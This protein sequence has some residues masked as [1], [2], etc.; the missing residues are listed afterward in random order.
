M[1]PY[2]PEM[3]KIVILLASIAVLV[4]GCGGSSKT[5]S[6]G[7]NTPVK[8]SG[9]TTNKGT[10]DLS[11]S[12]I[13]IE[14]DDFYFSPTFIKGGTPGATI[15]VHLKNDGTN[16]H[17]FTSTALGADKTL[18]PGE[19]ADVK[20]TLPQSG[21]SEFHCKFHQSSNG[22]QG[23]FFFKDGDTV[24]GGPPAASSSSSSSSYDYN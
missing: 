21:A 18:S 24:A 14:Q 17:N 19:S 12:S 5:S 7:S 15:T 11:G 4:A 20:V 22:M 2:D 13:E 8:L 23:A 9:S 10:K 6:G 3:R 16:P 1:S